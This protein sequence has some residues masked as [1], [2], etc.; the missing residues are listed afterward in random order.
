[1]AKIMNFSDMSRLAEVIG[2]CKGDVILN[3]PD[4]TR[5]NLKQNRDVLQ[6]LRY[7]QPA[8][9]TLE[10]SLSDKGDLPVIIGYMM[11]AGIA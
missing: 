4:S 11:E 2:R 9:G 1:M 8:G 7:M 6:L 5:F 10:L 3:L